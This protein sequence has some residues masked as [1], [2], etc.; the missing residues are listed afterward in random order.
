MSAAK[1]AASLRSNGWAGTLGSSPVEYSDVHN[2]FATFQVQII[3]AR[4]HGT[5]LSGFRRSDSPGSA[6]T[7]VG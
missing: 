7:R 6:V 2:R 5:R 3:A 1:I 4:S